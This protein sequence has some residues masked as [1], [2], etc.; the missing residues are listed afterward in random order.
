MPVIHEPF[1][2]FKTLLSRLL[3]KSVQPFGHGNRSIILPVEYDPYTRHRFDLHLLYQYR[4]GNSQVSGGRKPF[5][6]L[7]G[8]NPT[9]KAP[10][11]EEITRDFDVGGFASWWCKNLVWSSVGQAFQPAISLRQV[12]S[13]PESLPHIPAPN[14]L[15]AGANPAPISRLLLPGSSPLPCG[16]CSSRRPGVCN[17]SCSCRWGRLP[18]TEGTSPHQSC[19]VQTPR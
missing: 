7:C 12:L 9:T 4:T 2:P 1:N 16:P 14:T 5:F 19:P 10:R 17:R 6:F 8:R 3:L 18:W 13:G 11:H 15:R